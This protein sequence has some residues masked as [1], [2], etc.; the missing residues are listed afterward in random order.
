MPRNWSKAVPVGNDPIPYQ[1]EFG[2]SEP[3]M[4]DFYQMIKNLFDIS[5][6]KLDEL[7][8]EI[9]ATKQRLVGMKQDARPPRLATEADVL[10]DTKTRKC[11]KDVASAQVISGYNSSA[12]VDIDPMCLTSFSDNSTG[13]PALPYARDD[14]LIDNGA[15]APKPCLSPA[16]MRMRTAADGLL[17]TGIASTAM[18]T[19]FPRLFFSWSFGE[20]KK[21]TSRINNQLAPFWRR[22]IQTKS[23]KTLVFDPGGST[24]RLRACLFLGTWRALLF[25][26][27]FV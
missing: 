3:T 19:I 27:V 12:Q 16:E 15:A 1:D 20:T 21:R 11:V 5:N 4:A 10:T 9:R 26:E 24:C 2:S 25:E 7:T 6:R 23:R 18:R 13:P 14:A 22:V 8:E 17:P